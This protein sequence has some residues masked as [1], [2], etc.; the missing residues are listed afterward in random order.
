MFQK[1]LPSNPVPRFLAPAFL[2]YLKLYH[3]THIVPKLIVHC[4]EF[5]P[6]TIFLC[7]IALVPHYLEV[8]SIYEA[9]R[10]ITKSLF[11]SSFKDRTEAPAKSIHQECATCNFVIFIMST[12]LP[13]YWNRFKFYL[14]IRM[15][16]KR[17]HQISRK[18]A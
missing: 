1:V 16:L 13:R 12:R 2:R 6:S 11:D 18:C 9:L 3:K 8:S 7:I 5:F 17:T 10:S 15:F 14:P 4:V